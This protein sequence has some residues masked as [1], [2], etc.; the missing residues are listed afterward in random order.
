MREADDAQLTVP[1]IQVF[2]KFNRADLEKEGINWIK[3]EGDN[4]KN[5][6]FPIQWEEKQ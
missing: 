2:K 6:Y 5:N 4:T 3:M 1:L